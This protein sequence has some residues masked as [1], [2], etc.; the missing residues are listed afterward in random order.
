MITSRPSWAWLINICQ[1]RQ[2]FL[3][4]IRADLDLI[5]N[6]KCFAQILLWTN[7]SRSDWSHVWLHHSIQLLHWSL[8]HNSS[9]YHK[10]V[11]N[12]KQNNCVQGLTV[13]NVARRHLY[14]LRTLCCCAEPALLSTCRLMCLLYVTRNCNVHVISRWSTCVTSASHFSSSI[15]TSSICIHHK[16]HRV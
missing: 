2:I 15:N 5:M 10:A 14:R 1:R 8:I 9:K 3:T 11:E 16:T 12:A 7:L 13:W 4:C 6:A